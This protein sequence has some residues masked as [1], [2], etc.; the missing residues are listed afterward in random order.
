M[1][2]NIFDVTLVHEYAFSKDVDVGTN[3]K[4]DV[5]LS[6]DESQVTAWRQI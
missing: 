4:N 5:D 2:W 1:L 6:V 3:V